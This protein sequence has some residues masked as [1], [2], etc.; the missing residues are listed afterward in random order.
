MRAS[1]QSPLFE[2]TSSAILSTMSPS[3]A[4]GRN[5]CSAR[6]LSISRSSTFE[7]G[8]K[9]RVLQLSQSSLLGSTGYSADSHLTPS[10]GLT[11]HQSPHSTTGGH[12]LPPS[13]PLSGRTRLRATA[14]PPRL[15]STNS[16]SRDRI[17]ST[18]RPSEAPDSH[19]NQQLGQKRRPRIV[20]PAVNIYCLRG[21]LL[22]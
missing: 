21:G 14:T 2:A 16:W 7:Y 15:L 4:P 10:R 22:R 13:S 9:P 17:S 19:L 12:R 5:A 11:A 1:R 18:G 8:S 3:T 6:S 20:L